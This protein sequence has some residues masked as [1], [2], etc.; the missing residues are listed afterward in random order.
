[1]VVIPNVG[2]LS[3]LEAPEDFTAAVEKFLSKL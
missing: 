3:N 2:H 1:M